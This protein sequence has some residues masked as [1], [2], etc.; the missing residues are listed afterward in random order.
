MNK[1]L[2][3]VSSFTENPIQ[4]LIGCLILISLYIIILPILII[5][6]ILDLYD[7]MP[8]LNNL[9]H[10]MR[11]IPTSLMFTTIIAMAYLGCFIWFP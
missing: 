10:Y 2:N 9:L 6:E 1:E 8:R 4:C 11:I 3:P 5:E 7:I